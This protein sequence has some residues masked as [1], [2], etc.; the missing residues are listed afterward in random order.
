MKNYKKFLALSL[1]AAMVF[2]STMTVFASETGDE[3]TDPAPTAGVGEGEGTYE[4][5]EMK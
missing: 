5:G 4:G 2:G 1:T 3:G